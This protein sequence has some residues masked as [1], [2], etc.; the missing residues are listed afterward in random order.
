MQI[1]IDGAKET[2]TLIDTP[3][4]VDSP[5]D[6]LDILEDIAETLARLQQ[7]VFGAIYFHNITEKRMKGTALAVLDVFKAMCGQEFYP[8]MAFVTTMWDTVHKRVH[9]NLGVTHE[10]LRNGP[11]RLRNSVGVYQRL[12]D[13]DQLAKD[14]LNRFW[15]LA[16][17]RP[18]PPTLHLVKELG[19]GAR[20]VA[21][22]SAGRRLLKDDRTKPSD[23]CCAV[24]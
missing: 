9:R 23:G 1:T 17:D 8:H 15:L 10:E 21:S 11:M 3:G 24:M 12:A 16:R 2:F 22:T 14:L 18:A 20:T 19:P 6:N 7:E 4:F 13:D 5:D